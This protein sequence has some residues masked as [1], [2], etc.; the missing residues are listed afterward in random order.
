LTSADH[1]VRDVFVEHLCNPDGTP[2]TRQS[3]HYFFRGACRPFDVFDAGA[4]NGTELRYPVSVHG[5]VIGTALSNGEPVALAR[6]RS[7]FGLDALNLAAL[8]DM[9][10]GRATT[11]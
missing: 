8:H 9:T 11:P 3:D 1:D 2:P 10:E 7:T 4:L 5:P 6:K